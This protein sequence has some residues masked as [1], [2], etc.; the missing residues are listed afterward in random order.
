ME[1][2]KVNIDFIELLREKTELKFSKRYSKT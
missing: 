2:K 1:N